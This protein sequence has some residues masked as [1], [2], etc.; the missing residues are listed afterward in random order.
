MCAAPYQGEW[1]RA[2]VEQLRV[3]QQEAVVTFIDYGN[4]ET[5]GLGHLAKLPTT[6][7]GMPSQVRADG[8]FFL[9]SIFFLHR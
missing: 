8:F 1:Y 3:A 9:S 6:M 5:L 2:V 7:A 4:Q